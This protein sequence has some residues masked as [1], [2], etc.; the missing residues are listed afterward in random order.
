MH[1]ALLEASPGQ[2]QNTNLGAAVTHPSDGKSVR[3]CE[4]DRTQHVAV[5]A[6]GAD[7]VAK[8]VGDGG[9]GWPRGQAG[10]KPPPTR[11]RRVSAC[12]DA[13]PHIFP[14][15]RVGRGGGARG[16]LGA[17]APGVVYREAQAAL[18]SLEGERRTRRRPQMVRR[19]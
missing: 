3:F 9:W 14:T 1:R 8:R 7:G 17:A 10:R 6:V 19:T 15:R 16:G 13:E 4:R 11:R 5:D 12:G 2:F 18:T